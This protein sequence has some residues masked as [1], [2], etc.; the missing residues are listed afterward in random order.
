MAVGASGNRPDDPPPATY[1]IP[2]NNINSGLGTN[3]R[4]L[5][6]V[7]GLDSR[8]LFLVG[9]SSPGGVNEVHV[10]EHSESS[11]EL[12]LQQATVHPG[13]EIW[14]LACCPTNP[15]VYCSASRTP[16]GTQC[17][18]VKIPELPTLAPTN[19]NASGVEGSVGLKAGDGS[20]NFGGVTSLQF[21]T[22]EGENRVFITDKDSIHVYPT[23]L[24]TS[25]TSPV[26][27]ILAN[28]AHCK[29]SAAAVD[30]HQRDVLTVA[31]GTSLKM[32]DVRAGRAMYTRANTHLCGVRCVDYHPLAQFRVVSGGDDGILRI[33]DMR[34]TKGIVSA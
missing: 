9:A 5:A 7:P 16:E 13:G 17:H 10:L 23:D 24:P 28:P 30:P 2:R 8:H 3:G 25:Q 27:S 11:N 33:W 12:V 32:I 19:A 4:C 26:S 18:V 21:D 20:L 6:N 22:H 29:L 31:S 14:N 1:A 15:Q 34:Q